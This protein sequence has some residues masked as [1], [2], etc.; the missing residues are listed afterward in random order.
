MGVEE[1]TKVTCDKCKYVFESKIGIPD[2]WHY[3]SIV[4]VGQVML[5]PHCN[6]MI[7]F[8]SWNW[9]KGIN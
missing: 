4:E 1:I 7:D 9:Y 2:G 3:R 5:C 6:K 8:A